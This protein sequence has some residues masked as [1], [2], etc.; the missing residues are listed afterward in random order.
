MTD[1][2][3]S[4]TRREALG[5]ESRQRILAAATALMAERGYAGT[6]IAAVKKKSGLPSGSIYWHF[7][8]KEALLLS[9]IEQAAARW[10]EALP[11]TE[12]LTG[13]P[14]ERIQTFLNAAAQAL[15]ERPEFIRLILLISLERRDVDSTSLVPIRRARTLVRER[16]TTLFGGLLSS[17]DPKSKD[18]VARRFADF[19]L[20]VADG[21][22]I[23]HH[24]DRETTDLRAAF[25][26]MRTAL[27]VF[28]DEN[29]AAASDV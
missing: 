25:D 7:E 6:S 4:P 10:I 1:V 19:A 15:E 23:A 18:S 28:L 16:L 8:N 14:E 3:R 26:L 2:A 24:L 29:A 5:I 22:F 13:L 17:P 27:T 11:D 12:S 21:A 20:M 9:V